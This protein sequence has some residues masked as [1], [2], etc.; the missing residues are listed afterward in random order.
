MSRK[1]I[2][3]DC[4][5]FFAAVEMRDNPGLKNIPIAI[6]GDSHRRGVLCT[7]NYAARAYGVKSAMPTKMALQLCPDLLVLPTNFDK[8]K[9]ASRQ[10]IEIFKHYTDV[11]EV[12]S[13]DEAFL[14]V[15]DVKGYQNS[16]THIAKA[17]K[18][19]VYRRV[20]I[21]VSAGV[22]PNKFLAKVASD[23]QKP[24]GL[25]VITPDK[26]DA[27]VKMLPIEKISGVG[28]VTAEKLHQLGVHTCEDLQRLSLDTLVGNVGKFAQRLRQYSFGVDTRCVESR[29]ERKSCSIEK[30]FEQ[31]LSYQDV[32]KSLPL[33][34]KGLSERLVEYESYTHK[35]LVV[36]MK[37]KDFHQ[38]TVEQAGLALT[39]DNLQRLLSDAYQRREMRIRLIGIGMKFNQET[40][41]LELFKGLS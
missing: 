21:T 12:V 19:E 15:T 13:I 27:F 4:D 9:E 34:L 33:L 8:Y 6:G 16:A 2:H 22:A 32:L 26:V 5:C 35:S 31:D 25:Y 23:W 18:E 20:G 36:K 1:I 30:T 3:V 24:D 14:D 40:L 38:T 39:L 28:K 41:Q 7:A 11:I 37:F 10:I 17:I 29:R